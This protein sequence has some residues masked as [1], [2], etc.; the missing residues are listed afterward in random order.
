MI[1]HGPGKLSELVREGCFD[2]RARTVLA[3][4][5][6]SFDLTITRSCCRSSSGR[7]LTC[8]TTTSASSN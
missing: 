6:I 2:D 8:S 1:N 3:V 4:T 7:A 5:S